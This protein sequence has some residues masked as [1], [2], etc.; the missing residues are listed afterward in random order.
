MSK[1]KPPRKDAPRGPGRPPNGRQR[2]NIMIRPEVEQCLK[3]L[4]N[5]VLSDGI[6]RAAQIAADG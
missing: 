2:R 1:R 5:G 3:R 4:G 6:E